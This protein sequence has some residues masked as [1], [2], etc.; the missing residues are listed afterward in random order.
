MDMDPQCAKKRALRAR[1][2]SQVPVDRFSSDRLTTVQRLPPHLPRVRFRDHWRVMDASKSVHYIWIGTIPFVIEDRMDDDS[3]VLIEI[4]GDN[5]EL[6]EVE[7]PPRNDPHPINNDG[8][9]QGGGND[10]GG[11]MSDL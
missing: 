6:P 3:D 2:D 8:Q 9:P 1:N 11:T 4:F 5:S 7:E 10:Q